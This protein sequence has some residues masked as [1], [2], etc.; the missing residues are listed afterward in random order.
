MWDFR[1]IQYPRNEWGELYYEVSEVYYNDAG[2]PYGYCKAIAGA[3]TIENTALYIKLMQ[4]AL[5]LPPL[6]TTDITGHP[7]GWKQD[8]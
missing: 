6:K 1:L 3:D 5:T 4:E 7:D 8:E 2:E